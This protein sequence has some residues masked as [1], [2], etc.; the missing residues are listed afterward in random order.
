MP[1]GLFGKAAVRRDDAAGPGRVTA[2]LPAR[3][4]LVAIG[5]AILGLFPQVFGTRRHVDR[6]V[7]ADLHGRGVSVEHVLGLLG[8]IA[9]GHAVYFGVG[10][11]A[12]TLLRRPPRDSRRD[13]ASSRWCRSPASSPGLVAIPTGLIALRAPPHTFVVITIAFMFVFQL[14]AENFGFTGSLGPA[15]ADPAVVGLELQRRLLLRDR[16]RARR[17]RRLSWLVRRRRFGL[18]CSRS[19]TTRTGWRPR[20][21]RGPRRARRYVVSAIPVGMV[22]RHLRCLPRPDLPSSRS[23]RC[24]ICRSSLM[25]FI[26]GLGTVSGRCSALVLESLQQ[27]FTGQSA[28]EPGVP[29]HLRRAVP[30][31]YPAAAPARGDPE[32]RGSPRRGGVPRARA[33]DGRARRGGRRGRPTSSRPR[34]RD[35]R[36]DRGR[37]QCPSG[38][39]ASERCPSARCRCRRGRS[40]V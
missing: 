21:P 30:G 7:H 38:S 35:E 3:V 5:V 6:R 18:Q 28:R 22:G 14:G 24:S 1:N 32:R 34:E 4:L 40:P 37:G 17:D 39:A 27:Y 33:R 20:C 29:D 12:L 9:L 19:A 13:G 16:D 10:A 26:G 36:A 8:Y 23:I 25:A 2:R 31:G 11:Y 15:A